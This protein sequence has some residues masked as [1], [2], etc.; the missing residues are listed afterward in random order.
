MSIRVYELS[1]K[2]GISNKELIDIL[3]SHGFSLTSIAVVPAE[4][5]A[6]LENKGKVPTSESKKVEPS[7][8]KKNAP[9]NQKAEPIKNNNEKEK[10]TPVAKPS[11]VSP[12]VSKPEPTQQVNV[13]PE[14]V[15]VKQAPS[16][17]RE[18]VHEISIA[19]MTVAE[20]AE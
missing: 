8:S 2:L 6:I 7:E 15:L 1:K 12:T 13:A 11:T 5:L 10:Q 14:P 19:P 17:S 18:K 4:A 3:A 9:L 16:A 20:F